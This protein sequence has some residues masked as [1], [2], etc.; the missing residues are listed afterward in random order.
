MT[1]RI[2]IAVLLAALPWAIFLNASE[3]LIGWMQ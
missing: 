2:N 1:R 3:P